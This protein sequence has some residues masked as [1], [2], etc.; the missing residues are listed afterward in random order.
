MLSVNCSHFNLERNFPFYFFCWFTS[1]KRGRNNVAWSIQVSNAVTV[2]TGLSCGKKPANIVFYCVSFFKIRADVSIGPQLTYVKHFEHQSSF[3][4]SKCFRYLII[5]VTLQQPD[6]VDHIAEWET[7]T[8]SD[9]AKAALY[10]CGCDEVWFGIH[11]NHA[12]HFFSHYATALIWVAQA[13]QDHYKE[14]GNSKTT[15]EHLLSWSSWSGG[16]EV[17]IS[18]LCDLTAK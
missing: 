7:E 8:D 1:L 4:C 16:G 2:K 15:S 13:K 10:I 6:K 3:Q 17:T 9:L 11:L 18:Q 14:T 12:A 5:T